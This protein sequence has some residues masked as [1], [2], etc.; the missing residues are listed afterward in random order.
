LQYPI[1][2][3][4]SEAIPAD[5]PQDVQVYVDGVRA[6]VRAVHGLTGEVELNPFAHP[7]TGTQT[8][9]QPVLPTL[10][11]KV[12]CSYRWGRTTLWQDLAQRVF[13]RAT[14]VGVPGAHNI[15]EVTADDMV[16]TPLEEAATVSNSEHERIDW[17]WQE[18]VARNRWILEQGGERVLA[19]I[20][21]RAGMP[22][23]CQ[24]DGY[25]KQPMGDCK[26]CFGT[27]VIGGYEGPYAII[28]APDDA[29]RRKAQKD[30]GKA[31]EHTYEVWTGPTPLLSM[32]DFLVKF[33]NEHYSI[34][35][36]RMPTSRGQ[37]LQQ[38][39]NIG[40]I[41]AKDIRYKVPNDNPIKAVAV[42]F[43]PTTVSTEA[44]QS[45]T[46]N[47]S[48]PAER[49]LRGR[50]LAWLNTTYGGSNR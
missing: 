45:T 42:Q 11:S 28:V 36:V 22:C 35:P 31:I 18:A 47:Q 30:Q 37:I 40:A 12:T 25:H 46:N 26:I 21:K 41:D 19:Y 27:S 20:R 49:Q 50:S 4:G 8:L 9:V 38:H 10:T 13:Y 17:M 29:E 16:E 6:L 1:V 14:T 39:F 23:P 7:E 34:G 33:N 32:Q 3:E 5:S 24:Q 48:I 43:V 2:K 44:S 15:D